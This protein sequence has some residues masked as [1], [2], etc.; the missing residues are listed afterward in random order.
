MIS[1]RLSWNGRSTPGALEVTGG[2]SPELEQSGGKK[3]QIGICDDLVG[4][5]ARPAARVPTLQTRALAD[6][7]WAY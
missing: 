5:R 1:R 7:A 3:Y 4:T 6:L 2:S